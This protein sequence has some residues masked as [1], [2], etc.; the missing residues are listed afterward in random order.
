MYIIH[1]TMK[2]IKQV[3]FTK[4]PEAILR[5]FIDGKSRPG[6]H[7]VRE[8]HAAY[9]TVYNYLKLFIKHG[10][11]EKDGNLNR[12]TPKGISLLSTLTDIR[13][14]LDDGE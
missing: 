5:A 6:Y 8:S 12:I 11:M 2:D 7:A 1:H 10:L 3:F 9:S 13:E 14:F 4:Q